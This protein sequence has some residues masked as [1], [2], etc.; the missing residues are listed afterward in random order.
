MEI[1]LSKGKTKPT[2]YVTTGGTNVEMPKRDFKDGG[3]EFLANTLLKTEV[4]LSFGRD[5][6]EVLF[7]MGILPIQ[8]SVKLAMGVL[9]M[10]WLAV[11][12]GAWPRR[13]HCVPRY[14]I[15]DNGNFQ[16]A[17]NLKAPRT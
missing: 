16:R 9:Q 15:M 12:R 11:P 1:L 10:R 2:F 5:S 17:S 7:H 13:H 14:M 4:S 8:V 3:W 6:S